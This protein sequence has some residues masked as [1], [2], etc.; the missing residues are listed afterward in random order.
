MF[1][2]AARMPVWV[3]AFSGGKDS[4]AL[5]DLALRFLEVNSH[6]AGI[7]VVAYSDTLLDPIPLRNYALG[8]LKSVEKLEVNG[9]KIQP[10]VAAP[11]ET[12]EDVVEMIMVGGT[13][14]HQ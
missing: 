5:L 2:L 9:V 3:V 14:R 13:Q 8:I 6:N 12:G 4:S 10:L 1:R 7:L 11:L